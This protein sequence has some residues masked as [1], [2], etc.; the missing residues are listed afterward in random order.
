M[1]G[2]KDAFRLVAKVHE[3]RADNT[4]DAVASR[5]VV[6]ARR[7]CHADYAAETVEDA[8]LPLHLA[9]ISRAEVKRDSLGAEL[10]DDSVELLGYLGDSLV[11]SDALPLPR[12]TLTNALHGVFNAQGL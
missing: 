6:H 3:T 12:A 1:R 7:L 2:I 9:V 11:P 10:L 5:K 8:G 4:V